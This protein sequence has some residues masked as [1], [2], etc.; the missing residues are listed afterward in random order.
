MN[1]PSVRIISGNN[2]N[3]IA[4]TPRTKKSG[5]FLIFSPLTSLEFFA[6][7]ANDIKNKEVRGNSIVKI[8]GKSN[9]QVIHIDTLTPL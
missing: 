8:A 2:V 7:K 3:S 5:R 4:L 1:P 6:I 9:P